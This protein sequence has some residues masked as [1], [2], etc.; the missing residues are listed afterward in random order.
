MGEIFLSTIPVVEQ[1]DACVCRMHEFKLMPSSVF[2]FI[3]IYRDT[4]SPLFVR[5]QNARPLVLEN[6]ASKYLLINAKQVTFLKYVCLFWA[7]FLGWPAINQEPG[8]HV[9]IIDYDTLFLAL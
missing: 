5:F 3:W 8:R 7:F 6:A 9:W 2:R 1:I 4:S